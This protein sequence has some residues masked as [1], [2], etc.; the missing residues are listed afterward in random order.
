MPPKK[1]KKAAAKGKDNGPDADIKAEQ[2]RIIDEIH[3]APDISE[4]PMDLEM[5]QKLVETENIEFLVLVQRMQEI[6][7]RL[8][9][10]TE[11]LKD[12]KAKEDREIV[13]EKTLMT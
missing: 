5:A 13:D 7:R 1:G 2:R 8:V 4:Y 10:D 11:Y 3:K 9:A 12:Q 6:N